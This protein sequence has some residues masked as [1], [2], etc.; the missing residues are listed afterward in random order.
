MKKISPLSHI[1]TTNDY[2]CRDAS[3]YISGNAVNTV[4]HTA[5]IHTC[6]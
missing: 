3:I 5:I 1:Y 2:E 6:Q 4:C